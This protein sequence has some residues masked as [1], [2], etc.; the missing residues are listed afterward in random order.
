MYKKVREYLERRFAIIGAVLSL[1]AVTVFILSSFVSPFGEWVQKTN[2]WGAVIVVLLG[3]TIGL[4]SDLKYG[5]PSRIEV[6]PSETS[7]SSLERQFVQKHHPAQVD[8]I[9]HSGL[10]VSELLDSLK[11]SRSRI[12]LLLKHPDTAESEADKQV[13]LSQAI[14]LVEVTL[15]DYDKVEI[16]CYTSPASI[17]GKLFDKEAL[18]V[19]WYTYTTGL[20]YKVYGH[21]N[22]ALFTYTGTAE[23]KLLQAMFERAFNWLWTH[24]ETVPVMDAIKGH[25]VPVP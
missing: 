12:R 20:R 13:I 22:A 5:T 1:A 11:D 18:S 25:D 7:V 2:L 4:L 19:S 24:P 6:L 23:G 10:V 3:E 8:L 17:R 14:R 21:D 16:K 9:L 15:K